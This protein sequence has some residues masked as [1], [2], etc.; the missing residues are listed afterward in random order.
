VLRGVEVLDE[1]VLELLKRLPAPHVAA[2]ARAAR[3]VALDGDARVHP[4]GVRSDARDERI[5]RRREG[6]VFDELAVAVAGAAV[7]GLDEPIE[8]PGG[9]DLVGRLLDELLHRDGAVRAGGVVV[10]VAGLVLAGGLRHGAAGDLRDE[11][12]SARRGGVTVAD[13]E[14]ERC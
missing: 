2:R 9:L 4:G 12:R 5:D 14:A 1:R 3:Y 6:R 7:T 10:E 13:R 11:L 8:A